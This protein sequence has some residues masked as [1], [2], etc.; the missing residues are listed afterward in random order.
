[1]GHSAGVVRRAVSAADTDGVNKLHVVVETPPSAQPPFHEWGRLTRFLE[2]GRL[3]F[4]RERS[5]WAS[6]G[7]DKPEKVRISAPEDQA[8]YSVT[9]Q[10][11][12]DAI[13]DVEVLHASVLVHSYALAEFAAFDR[14]GIAPRTFRGIEDWG[15]ELLKANGRDWTY[16]EGGLAGAVETAVV[17]NVFAHGSRTF[18]A[19]ARRR[20][21]RAGARLGPE[22]APVT[23]TYSELRE[24][25][26]RLKSLLNAGGIGR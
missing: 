10:K 13:D 9:L 19:E 1:M 15:E 22:G 8:R 17:R 14:L 11:H 5:L 21:L 26:E 4:A 18:D 24:F 3:A 2:S 23:L 12:I 7:I 25:R 16:V 6:L 20:L